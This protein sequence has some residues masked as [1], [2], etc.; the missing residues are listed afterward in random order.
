[1]HSK[2]HAEEI[3]FVGPNQQQQ[4]PAHNIAILTME[5]APELDYI[6]IT[7]LPLST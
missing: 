6:K 2:L 1:V 7:F 3:V 4:Q 5:R